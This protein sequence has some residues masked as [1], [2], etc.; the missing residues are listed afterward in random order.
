MES[1]ANR[2]SQSPVCSASRLHTHIDGG[3][4][5]MLLAG[6]K[7]VVTNGQVALL[8]AGAQSKSFVSFAP[9]KNPLTPVR[10]L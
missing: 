5:K 2:C 4:R 8:P 3:F 7:N 1:I 6:M 9:R 10:T